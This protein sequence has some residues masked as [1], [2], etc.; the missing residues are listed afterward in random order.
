MSATNPIVTVILCTYQ[1][2]H[3]LGDAIRSVTLQDFQEWE[4]LVINDGGPDVSQLVAGFAD[5]RIRYLPQEKNRGKSVCCNI[6]LKEARGRYIAYIDDDDMWYPN[7]LGVLTKALDENP[8]AG[9]AYSDLYAVS[10]IKDEA[11]GRRYIL[12]KRMSV[13]RDFCRPFMFYFNHTLHV[14]L[15]HRKDAALRVGGY[16]EK[17]T[18]LI[19]WNITR[20]LVFLYDFVHV[21]I[22]T[23]EYYMPLFKSDRI[24]IVQRKDKRKF[25]Q[26]S[27]IIK[28]DFPPE[29]WTRVDRVD[30]IFP[31]EQWDDELKNKLCDLID[32]ICHPIRIILVNNGTGLSPARCRKALG[33]LTELSNIRIINSK[34]KIEDIFAFRLAAGQ[35]DADYLLL[36]TMK[37]QPK[38][39]QK[40]V[41]A[42]L[43]FLKRVRQSEGVK[44]DVTEEAESNF[45]FL[46]NRELFLRK[47]DPGYA[48]QAV[49]LNK[50]PQVLPEGF[51]F[52]LVMAEARRQFSKGKYSEALQSMRQARKFNNG[53]PTRAFSFDFYTRICLALKQYGEAEKE[54]QALARA[55]YRPDNLIRLGE[56]LQAQGR[57]KEAVQAYQE[58]FQTLGMTEN[59][60]DSSV[61]PIDFPRELNGFTALIGLGESHLELGDQAEAAR[62]FRRASRLRA[63]SHR[64]FLGFAKLFLATN[65][66]DQAETALG[67]AG[68]RD[69]RDPETHRLLGKLCE[70]RKRLDLAFTCYLKAFANAKD[71]EKNLDPLYFTGANLGKWAELKPVFQEF[72]EHRPGHVQAV[73]KLTTIH[74]NLGE[75]DQAAEICQSAL[76]RNPAY[77]PLKAM[78]RKIEQ[79]QAEKK[80]AP[81]EAEP[82]SEKLDED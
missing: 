63:N 9:A 1:R 58:G 17:V 44:W 75:V 27:R 50:L 30:V 76:N 25:K 53:T 28:A 69:G 5:P 64:P 65:Q 57:H 33:E 29:P 80:P 77:A 48:D 68:M 3:Y 8:E 6:G 21:Q 34:Q 14:S 16:N 19:D 55:G 32:E 22:P 36:A 39:V 82:Q 47:S 40:R 46:I 72:L 62:M 43:D 38:A 71:D 7:H 45:E 20:K 12:D 41:M 31:V 51:Q 49:N 54:C 59:D 42:G 78:A 35:S 52:D 61:F 11:T 74:L 15:M 26:N 2:P 37:L 70:R 73:T 24:S 10:F 67:N 81:A 79:A 66:L 56:I 13:S 18:S 4:L 23:G 60:L